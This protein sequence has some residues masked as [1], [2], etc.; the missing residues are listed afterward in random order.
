MKE[1]LP[2]LHVNLNKFRLWIKKDS[3]TYF[4]INTRLTADLE[5]PV[6]ASENKSGMS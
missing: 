5:P 4:K 6:K 2:H 3:K 1:T